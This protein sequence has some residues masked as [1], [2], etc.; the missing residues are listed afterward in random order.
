MLRIGSHCIR[1]SRP[2]RMAGFNDGMIALHICC[3]SVTGLSGTTGPDIET[4][5]TLALG[6]GYGLSWYQMSVI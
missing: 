1:P 4:I 6:K 2:P 5:K 3:A